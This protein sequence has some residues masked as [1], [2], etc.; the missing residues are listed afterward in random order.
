MKND[1]IVEDI[2]TRGVEQVLPSKDGLAD[3]MAQ[4]KLTLYLGIDPTGNQ[5]H[6]GH[7]VVL[8]KLQQ[9]ADLGHHV[10][11]LIGN[12]TVKI[13]DPTGRDKTRPMLT[14]EEIDANFKTWKE[15]ASKVLDFSKIEIRKNG[16]WL[17]KL[18]FVD[19]VKLM[20]RFTVQQLLERDMFQ[21]RLKK[22]LPI[23]THEIMYPLL[24]GYDS[25]AMDVDLELGGND[26]TFNMMVGRQLQRDMNHHEKFVLATP[27]LVGSDGRKMGKSFGNF[28]SMTETPENMFGKVMSIVDDIII[29][30]FMLLTDVLTD[31]IKQMAMDLESG[32]AHPLELKKKLAFTI[33]AQYHGEA[34]AKKAQENFEKTVQNKEAPTE[35]QPLKVVAGAT[36]LDAVVTSGVTSSKSEAKRLI[37]QGGVQLD[38]EKVLDGAVV[39]KPAAKNVLKIGKR[40]FFKIQ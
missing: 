40:N 38:G 36:L 17:D 6:L 15:Q 39:L 31:E 23:F 7:S 11:L 29:Q 20:S 5:L 30:Y 1:M 2:L 28:I 16:D 33:T 22:N 26:Q 32:K 35:I 10:I 3:L 8:R 34:E 12:G 24:Q 19:M 9:F 14:E 21:E 37:E 13:G 25:V 27:L 4:K 18:T